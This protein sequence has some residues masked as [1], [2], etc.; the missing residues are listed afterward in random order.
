MTALDDAAA[1][2]SGE[3]LMAHLATSVDDRPHVAPVWYDYDDGIVRIVTGGRKLEN[4]RRNPR[5]ALSIQRD[6]AGDALWRVTLLGT[7]TIVEDPDRVQAATRR[8]YSTYMGDDPSTWD[9]RYREQLEAP[10]MPLLEVE[11]GSATVEEY[12]PVDRPGDAGAD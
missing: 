11:V 3:R 1:R 6:E 8:I 7:A 5:V 2:I 9:A 12:D 4:V 10:S